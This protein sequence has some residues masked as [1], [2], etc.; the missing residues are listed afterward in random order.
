MDVGGALLLPSAGSGASCSV[1]ADGRSASPEAP[2]VTALDTLAWAADARSCRR[3]LLCAY[4]E[5]SS[6]QSASSRSGAA[7]EGGC[8][9][10]CSFAAA[11]A[12]AAPPPLPAAAREAL[13]AARAGQTVTLPAG[14]WSGPLPAAAAGVVIEATGVTL[15]GEGT[16][17]TVSAPGVRVRDVLRHGIC[18][19]CWDQRSSCHHW[20]PLFVAG[21]TW[22]SERPLEIVLA[23]SSPNQRSLEL[24]LGEPLPKERPEV[25]F[26]DGLPVLNQRRAGQPRVETW[27]AAALTL[28]LASPGHRGED[29][30]RLRFHINA[31]GQL[32]LEAE[33]LSSGEQHGPLCLGP[34]R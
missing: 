27:P 4:F 22:P 20:Q 11:V 30:L 18:L 31:S 25:M 15:T 7:G 16:L 17:L 26:I 13:R 28:P 21:Q 32:L 6:K 1:G 19:R 9:D 12:E 33:D 34:V 3:A 2:D 29:R 24:V 23:C 14:V 8:C 5:A 10:N